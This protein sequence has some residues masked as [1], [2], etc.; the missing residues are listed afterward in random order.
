MSTPCCRTS[1]RCSTSARP[2]CG[3][4]STSAARGSVVGQQ[5]VQ[6]S[7]MGGMPSMQHPR[8]AT[9]PSADFRRHKYNSIVAAAGEPQDADVKQCVYSLGQ[10]ADSAVATALRCVHYMCATTS[11]HCAYIGRWT[12]STRRMSTDEARQ[13]L[14]LASTSSF[15][16]AMKARDK[17]MERYKDDP[18][19]SMQVRHVGVVLQWRAWWSG[20]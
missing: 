11:Y 17:R 4:Q 18:E 6:H 1:A 3:H 19:K 7:P 15:D 10:H 14:G 5:P 12:P 13:L 16:Q 20:G 2:C 8:H 9:L